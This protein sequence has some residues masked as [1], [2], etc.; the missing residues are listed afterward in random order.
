ME[1]H[2]A[3]IDRRVYLL[4]GRG[5][6]GRLLQVG[7]WWWRRISGVANAFQMVSRRGVRRYMRAGRGRSSRMQIEGWYRKEDL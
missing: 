6:G 2:I 1:R 7:W 3:R 4:N 5:N